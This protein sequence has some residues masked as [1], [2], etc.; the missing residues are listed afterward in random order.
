MWLFKQ[1]LN[2]LIESLFKACVLLSTNTAKT[3]EN[4]LTSH[5]AIINYVLKQYG[6]DENNTTVDAD[7]G[8]FK[9]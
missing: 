7:I 5:Y 9:Q 1:C 8:T 2:I 6:M 4:C 3:Q